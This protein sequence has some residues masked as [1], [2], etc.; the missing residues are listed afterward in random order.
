MEESHHSV[1]KR[2]PGRH[3]L[4][5]A[6]FSVC[7]LVSIGATCSDRQ[8]GAASTEAGVA[9]T[10][11]PPARPPNIVFIYTDDQAEWTLGASGNYQAH[12]P[13]LD[14]LASEGAYM[15]NSL[16]TTP[17]CTPAR[18]SI[19][20]SR[21]ASEFNLLDFI[22]QPGHVLYDEN[23]DI[24]LPPTTVTFAEVLQ[25]AGYRTGLVGKWH[26]GDWTE[27]PD[28]KYH[29]TNH[30]FDYFMGLTGGGTSAD[31]PPLEEDGV[32]E[33]HEGLTTD[34]LTDRALD[35]IERNA[36]EP[37]LLNIHYRAP[38]GPWL[39]VD[40]ADWAPLA[41]ME[42]EVPHPEYPGLDVDRV[43]RRMKEY[44]A[45]TAGV[46]RNVG[47]LL[48]TLDRLGLRENT[49][50]V[51]TSDHGYNMG[52]NGIEHKGNGIWI[53]RTIPPDTETIPG[54]Y[55]PNLYDHSLR[56]PAIVRWP[57]VVEPGLVI[58]E[59]VSSLDWYPSLVEMAGVALPEGVP[60]RG[61]SV[62]PL[63]SGKSPPDWDNDFYAEYS[64]THYAQ[65][66]MRAYRTPEWKLVV[67]FRNAGRDELYHL[68]SD[69]EE[70]INRINDASPE[71]QAARERLRERIVN[72]MEQLTDP[73]LDAID[74]ATGRV[75]TGAD[76]P[77]APAS[78]GTN[79]VGDEG[80]LIDERSGGHEVASRRARR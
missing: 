18:A 32:V 49:V 30:G 41:D 78:L 10:S 5:A 48:E 26:L 8:S 40:E 16:V 62:V 33:T 68:A 22:A 12:T 14:R 39:P 9:S 21:Y 2:K 70:R 56:V 54:R 31:D 37:F 42:M 72:K 67:D 66:Y 50:V 11:N 20:T 4:L 52:H 63:L 28:Q 53:T 27:A 71:A 59:T 1:M 51:F 45:S 46:D 7:S 23:A 25:D 17:V 60:V 58:D 76:Y 36:E 19:M 44:L 38:H 3:R 43:R 61:R 75:P 24:G 34:I 35:F 29:P 73:L 80:R 47:R 6:V 13:N 79:A 65:A 55:R 77:P 57:G 69:P 74:P 15:T 64:M